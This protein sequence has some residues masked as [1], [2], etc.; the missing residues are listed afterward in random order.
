VPL[1]LASPAMAAKIA[2]GCRLSAELAIKGRGGRRY[3]IVSD[4]E[5]SAYIKFIAVG[6]L[7][8]NIII[9][10]ITVFFPVIFKN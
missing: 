8:K 3:R 5:N 4:L 2:E 10:Q 9:P 1:H 6:L 7:Q